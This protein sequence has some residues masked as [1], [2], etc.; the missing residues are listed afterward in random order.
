MLHKDA[1]WLS[2]GDLRVFPLRIRSN[3]ERQ[4]T[5]QQWL[6]ILDATGV[7]NSNDFRSFT[8]IE[9]H[10]HDEFRIGFD[11]RWVLLE[12]RILSNQSV[13]QFNNILEKS[14]GYEPNLAKIQPKHFAVSTYPTSQ[15]GYK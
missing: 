14:F 11:E 2:P 3:A 15:N 8:K 6:D 1:E 13:L 7:S 10:I 4:L 5:A 9:K 12:D